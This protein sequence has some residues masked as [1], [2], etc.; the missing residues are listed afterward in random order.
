MIM[1]QAELEKLP[2]ITYDPAF[3]T[4]LIQVIPDRLA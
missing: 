2:V 3:Q 4:G 1:A